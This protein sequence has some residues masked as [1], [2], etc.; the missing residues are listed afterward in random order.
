MHPKGANSMVG[1]S[2]KSTL[3]VTISSLLLNGCGLSHKH[4]ENGGKGICCVKLGS[5]KLGIR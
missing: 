5:T 2:Y 1:L 3:A 4:V